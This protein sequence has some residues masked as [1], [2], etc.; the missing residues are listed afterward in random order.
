MAAATC[1]VNQYAHG[2][3]TN[4]SVIGCNCGEIGPEI[5]TDLTSVTIRKALK[6]V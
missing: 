1:N 4:Y 6:F 5:A 3:A 2:I